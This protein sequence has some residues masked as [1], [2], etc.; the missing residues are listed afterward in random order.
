MTWIL[1]SPDAAAG[2]VLL[3]FR[4]DRGLSQRQAAAVFGV[5]LRAWQYYE[6]DARPVPRPLLRRVVDRLNTP[7][8]SEEIAQ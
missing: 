4:K 1:P 2:Y 7:I 5:S 8:T 3:A 6:G